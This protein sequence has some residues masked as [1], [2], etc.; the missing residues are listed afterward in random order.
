MTIMSIL[1]QLYT[2][3]YQVIDVKFLDKNHFVGC[4]YLFSINPHH[5][6]YVL[7]EIIVDSHVCSTMCIL[8]HGCL[9]VSVGCMKL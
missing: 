8:D 9:H 2:P 6:A 5:E 1:A 3:D 7:V 4:S